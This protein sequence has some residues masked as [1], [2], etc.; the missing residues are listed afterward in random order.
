MRILNTV[1]DSVLWLFQDNPA[2][3]KNLQKEAEKRGIDSKRLVFA[4]RLSMPD[5][6]ARQRYADLFI[7]TLP[8]NAHT[9]TSDAL[10]AGLPVLTLI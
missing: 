1:N 7:D 9:T 8:Y 6:L 3:A 10:W 5:H 2:V 4:E